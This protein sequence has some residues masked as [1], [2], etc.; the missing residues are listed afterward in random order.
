MIVRAAN[1]GASPERL[2]KALGFT[3]E[4]IRKKFKLLQGICEEVAELLADTNCPQTT[5]DVLRRMSCWRCVAAKT[6]PVPT[7]MRVRI[8]WRRRKS[9]LDKNRPYVRNAQSG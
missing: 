4:T 8:G 1:N 7:S 5:F 2:A 3:P 9:C 6:C